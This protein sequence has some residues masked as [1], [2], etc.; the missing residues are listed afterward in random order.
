MY[1]S[2]FF[3]HLGISM[4]TESLLF[5]TL[6]LIYIVFTIMQAQ[7]E[8]TYC[9]SKYPGVYQAY[10]KETSRWIGLKKNK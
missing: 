7:A 6:T 10:M 9:L 1:V 5:F 2:M 4:V 3:T 8:E